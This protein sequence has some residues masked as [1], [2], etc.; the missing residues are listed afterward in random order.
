MISVHVKF[1]ETVE[2]CPK[3]GEHSIMFII[4]LKYFTLIYVS[5]TLYKD[6]NLE[7]HKLERHELEM[8]QTAI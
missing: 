3:F 1:V 4:V 2:K 8:Y 6:N 7:S 5:Y